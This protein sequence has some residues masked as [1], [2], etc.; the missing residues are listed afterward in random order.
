MV[1]FRFQCASQSPD[2]KEGGGKTRAG[3]EMRRT[4]KS[5]IRKRMSAR[6]SGTVILAGIS[7]V[8]LG[9]RVS[10]AL[11]QGLHEDGGSLKMCSSLSLSAEGAPFAIAIDPSNHV[12]E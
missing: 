10:S 4:Q 1:I 5:H 6:T 9:M 7:G 12:G 8:L 2:E 3:C 11:I